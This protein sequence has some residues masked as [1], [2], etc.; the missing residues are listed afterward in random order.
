M[1]NIKVILAAAAIYGAANVASAQEPVLHVNPKWE[2]C[3]IQLDPSL[4]QEAWHQFAREAA[5][6]T[7]FRSVTDARPMGALRFELSVLKWNTRIDETDDAWNNTFVHPDSQHWLI[8]GDDLPF[9][10]LMMRA[11]VSR[12][13]DVAAFWGERPGANYGVAGAQVQ[14]SIIND[15]TRNWAL[16]ARAN[17]V[18]LY[19]PADVNLYVSGVDLIASR[20]FKVAPDWLS[21][22]PYAGISSYSAYAHEKT[23][24]VK[25]DDEEIS[26]SQAMAGAVA[27]IKFVRIGVEYNFASV[28]T[29]SYK[30]GASF[31]F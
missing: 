7:Y 9:P 19:G 20:T 8:G 13:V 31:K 15:T 4:T 27:E 25:L 16:S 24:S 22:S 21:V 30:L 10:V 5:L 11:G 18:S 26:G 14:Y 17:L 2:E 1:K 6:V 3:S 29:L 12:K 28:N 23:D